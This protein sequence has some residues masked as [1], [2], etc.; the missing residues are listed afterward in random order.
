[1]E[2]SIY[3]GIKILGG[4]PAKTPPGIIISGVSLP[5]CIVL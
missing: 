3:Y 4:K 2:G 1:M 5:G